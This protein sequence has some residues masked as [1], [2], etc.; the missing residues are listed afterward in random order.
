MNMMF[1]QRK[2]AATGNPDQEIIPVTSLEEVAMRFK[3]DDDNYTYE[4]FLVQVRTSKRAS[5]PPFNPPAPTA[6]AETPAPLA[7][8]PAA[9]VEAPKSSATSA[10]KVDKDDIS[11]LTNNADLLLQA[12]EVELARN[13]YRALLKSGEASDVAYA[14]LA[15]CA[16]REGLVDQAI[17][18]AWDSVAF[19]PNQKGYQIL[20]QLL[21]QQGRDQEASQALNRALKSLRL[22]SQEQAEYYKMIGNCQSRLGNTNEAESAFL[23][24]L[25]LNPSS[26]DVQSN[27]GSLY[28]EQG[29]INDAKRRYQDALAANAAND[30]AWVGLGLC[31]VAVDDKESAHEAF[32]RS[33]EKNLR[34]STAIFHLVKCAYEIKKYSTAEKMLTNYVEIAPVSPSLLY[35]LAGLQFHVGKRKEA[36]STAKKIL[37]IRGDH[38]G[39]KDLIKRIESD[40]ASA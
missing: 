40:S 6:K 1:D 11:F 17:Q 28:L 34:N 37:Q 18:F 2:G 15:I 10:G 31:Y 13:I 5:P 8:A 21:V 3:N 33:L 35:S 30:K 4:H 23:S 36:S 29:R 24:A 25:Q 27:L 38:Q 32:A 20:A 12:G 26:D 22:N 16:D 19:A 14:G 7:A 39:A 9:K